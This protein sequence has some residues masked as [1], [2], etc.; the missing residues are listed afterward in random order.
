LG[1]FPFYIDV[2]G[3]LL[4][5]CPH[6]LTHQHHIQTQ[7]HRIKNEKSALSK[8]VRAFKAHFRLLITGTPLQNDLHELW[9]L[10]NYI[11]PDVFDSSDSFDEWFSM[12]KGGGQ[13]QSDNVIRKLHQVRWGVG[14]IER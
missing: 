11:M 3:Y 8:A 7:A 13:Q 12:D 2:R 6:P 10:L 9:A 4:S 5:G 14:F 1:V